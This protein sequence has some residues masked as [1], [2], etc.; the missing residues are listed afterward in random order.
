[1]SEKKGRYFLERDGLPPTIE[2]K[3][4]M[5][6]MGMIE[7]YPAKKS[8]KCLQFAEKLRKDIVAQPDRIMASLALSLVGIEIQIQMAYAE[9]IGH[10]MVPPGV[11]KIGEIR[12][13]RD[14]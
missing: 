6:I 9:S 13:T 7:K 12:V 14:E 4:W 5:E 1:M 2:Q 11:R 8:K 3:D 10:P